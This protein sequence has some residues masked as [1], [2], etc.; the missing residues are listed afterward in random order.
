MLAIG[1]YWRVSRVNTLDFRFSV[2]EF[3]FGGRGGRE[4][5]AKARGSGKGGN[6]AAGVGEAV[7]V[8]WNFVVFGVVRF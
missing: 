5:H 2:F 8:G 3:R 1:G 6:G 4:S 7:V